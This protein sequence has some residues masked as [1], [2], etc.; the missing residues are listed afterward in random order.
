MPLPS[1]TPA[2][3]AGRHAIAARIHELAQA[4]GKKLSQD[5]DLANLLGAIQVNDPIPIAAFAVVADVL[6]AILAADQ[7]HQEEQ[8]TMP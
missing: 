2:P 4:H 7:H 5:T 8:E 1:E 6:F 3:D